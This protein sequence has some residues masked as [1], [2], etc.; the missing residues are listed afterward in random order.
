MPLVS[1]RELLLDAERGGYSLPAINFPTLE[2]LNPSLAAAR[3]LRAPIIMQM[4]MPEIYHFGENAVVGCVRA[5]AERYGVSVALHLDHGKEYAEIVRCLRRGFTSVMFDGSALPFAENIAAT[6]EVA[7]AAK[8]VGVTVEGEVGKILGAEDTGYENSGGD[9]MTDPGGAAEFAAATGVDCLAVA[10]GTAHGF[11]KKPPKLD[12]ERL[13]AI[14]KATDGLPIVLHG[15]TGIPDDAVRTA[16]ELGIRKINFSTIVKS[17]YIQAFCGFMGE[18]PK[19]SNIRF[20][21]E[22]AMKKVHET[23]SGFLKLLK[24]DGRG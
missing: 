8:A 3:D 4:A 9:D 16:V 13:K 6:R 7:K 24:C 18:H 1:M 21:S 14:R 22:A 15:G 19:E 2:I 11:Y 17:D 10:I 12:F 23:V 5:A 20:V